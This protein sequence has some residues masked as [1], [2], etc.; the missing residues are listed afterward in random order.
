MSISITVLLFGPLR[1]LVGEAQRVVEVED[2]ATAQDVVDQLRA[3]HEV[4]HRYRSSL[5]MA[6]NGTYVPSDVVVRSG[7]ELALITP[8][9]GG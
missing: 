4:L 6:V 5:R 7:D 3:D 8:T 9:S 1:D 2:G